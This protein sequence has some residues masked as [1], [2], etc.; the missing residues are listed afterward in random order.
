MKNKKEKNT[1]KTNTKEKKI[2]EFMKEYKF[3]LILFILSTGFF[4][5]QHAMYISWDFSAYVLNAKY[6]F[7]DGQYFEILRP[8]M[9]PFILGI[10]SFAGWKASEFI[11]IFLVSLLFAYSS[12]RLAKNAKMN[13]SLFY[14]LSLGIYVL[15]YGLVN[16][17]ELLFLLF[18]QLF[19]SLLIERKAASGL[20]L[21]LS[22]LSRYTALGLFPLLL[23]HL[24]LK[25]IIR[26]L[27]LFGGTISLWLLY[28]FLKT[29]N[30]L[31]S[32]ADQ[33]ANNILYRDYIIQPFRI[34][35]IISVQNILIPFFILGLSLVLWKISKDVYF[36]INQKEKKRNISRF[37]DNLR[38]ELIMIFL[39]LFFVQSYAGTPVKH[40]RYLFG[41]VIPTVYF[42]C[43]GIMWIIEKI[44]RLKKEKKGNN[45]LGISALLI[46]VINI[47]ILFNT[48]PLED[49]D[50]PGKYISS[51]DKLEELNMSDCAV[52][53]NSWVKLNYYGQTSSQ[54]PKYEFVKQEIVEGKV[55]VLFLNEP[56]PDYVLN[57]S[58]M[59][60][61]PVVYSNEQFVIVNSGECAPAS[62]VYYFYLD[63]K[64]EY[65]SE[66]TGYEVNIN[67][68]FILFRN[69]GFVEKTCNFVNL[70]GFK[71]DENRKYQ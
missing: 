13:P 25:K 47:I 29:G 26:S 14:A 42:S 33:Y 10:F 58:F 62:E 35:H 38:L 9:M 27:L 18:L 11:F 71:L 54:F 51:I 59:N 30:F 40:E 32:I 8:P 15:T 20:F 3:V 55:L 70:N 5:W 49:H 61:L 34:S 12:V 57:K 43:F 6:L 45:I 41:L 56:E 69:F 21:G 2:F 67:P 60:S 4:L 16:G 24:N 48:S 22:A 17:T 7:A 65:I 36:A 37:V 52:M 39:F 44:P 68:C 31:T 46:F 23:L 53:S 66:Q 64:K 28:N 1:E 19:V 50:P 63:E